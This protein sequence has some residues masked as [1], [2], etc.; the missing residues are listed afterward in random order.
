MVARYADRVAVM[1]GGRIVEVAPARELYA[2]PQHPYT[3]GLMASVPRLDGGRRLVP[4]EGQPPDLASLPLGC[5]FAPR[6]RSMIEPCLH[7]RPELTFVAD[8]HAKACFAD[9]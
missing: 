2:R 4:I 7:L 9:V 8:R 1:Y 5:S 3:L 6:C